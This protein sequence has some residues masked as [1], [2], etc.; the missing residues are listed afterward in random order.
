ME[1]KII[2]K[3]GD[4][5][6]RSTVTKKTGTKEYT[7]KEKITIYPS[8]KSEKQVIKGNGCVF[9]V[10]EYG[11]INSFD[12]DKELIWCT[13]CDTLFSF[14]KNYDCLEDEDYE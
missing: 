8:Y 10:D 11:D 13:D 7:L 6:D 12:V 4:I 9:L 3:A 5:P 2:L 14:L 1:I